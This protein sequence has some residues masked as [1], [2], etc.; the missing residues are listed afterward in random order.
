VRKFWIIA[1]SCLLCLCPTAALAEA[2]AAATKF[3]FKM[4]SSPPNMPRA[5]IGDPATKQLLVALHRGLTGKALRDAVGLSEQELAQRIDA[6]IAERLIRSDG[7]GNHV[8]TFP[9]ITLADAQRWLRADEGVVEETARLI[10][11]ELP[12][13]ETRY[14]ALNGFRHLSFKEASLLV[15]S[16][17]LLDA[18]QIG[19]V[20][21]AVLNV[22]RPTRGGGNYYLALI[23]KGAGDPVEPLGIYGNQVQGMG[24]ITAGLYGNKRY[25]GPPNLLRLDSAELVRDFGFAEGTDAATGRKALAEALVARWRD[26]DAAIEPSREGGLKMLQLLGPD[27]RVAIPIATAED[28]K[29]LEALAAFALPDLAQILNRHRPTLEQQFRAS[30]YDEEGVTFEEFFMWWY[31]V[32]YTAVTDRLIQRGTIILPPTGGVTYLVLD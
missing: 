19:D 1:T 18:W 11:R 2:A 3:E 17:V 10:E 15:L 13:I 8:P 26:P 20:E 27:G 28:Q 4:I 7:R 12:E 14:A 6:L 25:E 31:H 9:V 29:R 30:G 5:K 22:S 21:K 16:D 32:Y 24:A 23:E